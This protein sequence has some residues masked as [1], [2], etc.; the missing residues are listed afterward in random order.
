MF[1]CIIMQPLQQGLYIELVYVQSV[2]NITQSN[3]MANGP[4]SLKSRYAEIKIRWP[5]LST[6]HFILT[7]W[8]GRSSNLNSKE[9]ARANLRWP[10]AIEHASVSHTVYKNTATRLFMTSD[11]Y[12]ENHR[13]QNR[14]R[15]LFVRIVHSSE[16][17]NASC[18]VGIW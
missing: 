18:T 12:H 9:M 3:K 17:C 14:S 4:S 6:I 16:Q 5:N 1:A 11:L 8:D 2:C 13:A 10:H 15:E 7:F